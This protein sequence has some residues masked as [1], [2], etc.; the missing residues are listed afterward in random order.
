LRDKRLRPCPVYTLCEFA[1]FM[2]VSILAVFRDF[3]DRPPP[4]LFFLPEVFSLLLLRDDLE[5]HFHIESP[6]LLTSGTGS[7]CP[8]FLFSSFSVSYVSGLNLCPQRFPVRLTDPCAQD[9]FPGSKARLLSPPTASQQCRYLFGPVRFLSPSAPP[10]PP[11]P[12]PWARPSVLLKLLPYSH[13]YSLKFCVDGSLALTFSLA[14][15]PF[16]F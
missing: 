16:F 3:C 2:A 7:R 13:C 6:P 9:L 5:T 15:G 8:F 11:P 14:I 1:F 4:S 10:P 12:P